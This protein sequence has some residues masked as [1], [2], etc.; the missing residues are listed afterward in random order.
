MIRPRVTHVEKKS[1]LQYES[2]GEGKCAQEPG[3][4]QHA[5]RRP[6]ANEVG[7]PKTTE[8]LPTRGLLL[9]QTATASS[10]SSKMPGGGRPASAA[11]TRAL[12]R[13]DAIPVVLSKAAPTLSGT[14]T[15]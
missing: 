8:P 6:L 4:L 9:L 5:F 13:L 12:P 14:V 10:S 3:F 1:H 7:V 2:G 15:M 11:Q